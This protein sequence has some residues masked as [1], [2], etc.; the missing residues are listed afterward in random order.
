[1]EKDV[2]KMNPEE[3]DYMIN[4]RNMS[5]LHALTALKHS[6]SVKANEMIKYAKEIE[7]YMLGAPSE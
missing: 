1:M 4:I 3:R 5:M 6:H 2:S 7:T